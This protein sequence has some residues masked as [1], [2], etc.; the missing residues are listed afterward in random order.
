MKKSSL[1]YPEH[2]MNGLEDQ[3]VVQLSFLASLGQIRA[4]KE[5]LVNQYDPNEKDDNGC[6][7]VMVAAQRNDFEMLQLLAK[8]GASLDVKDSCGRTPLGWAER[9]KNAKMVSFI[10]EEYSKAEI[11][12]IVTPKV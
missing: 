8:Y 11:K 12:N 1:V 3:P 7:A 9:Y 4:V 10:K 6:T 2:P 5:M